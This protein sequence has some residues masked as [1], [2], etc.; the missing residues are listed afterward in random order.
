MEKIRNDRG[1]SATR[2]A[3]AVIPRN[4]QPWKFDAI[5]RNFVPASRPSATLQSELDGLKQFVPEGPVK[6]RVLICRQPG[7]YDTLLRESNDVRPVLHVHEYDL[8]DTV[9]AMRHAVKYSMAYILREELRQYDVCHLSVYPPGTTEFVSKNEYGADGWPGPIST[10]LVPTTKDPYVIVALNPQ[11]FTVSVRVL[12]SR[13]PGKYDSLLGEKDVDIRPVLGE[14]GLFETVDAMCHVVRTDILSNAQCENDVDDLKVYPPGT[15]EFVSKNEYGADGGPGPIS[16]PLV[17]T[18]K[19]PY[20]IVVHTKLFPVRVRVLISRQPGKYEI[21]GESDVRPVLNQHQLRGTVDAMR[22]AVMDHIM[23][24][25]LRR[26][27]VDDL[28]VYPPGTTEFVSKNEYV[29]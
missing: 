10:P 29:V 4:L 23:A 24:D 3:T 20:V 21:V 13:Q 28:K 26:Y 27:E 8:G 5:T 19:D 22:H 18:M 17:P 2:E 16:T 6:V 9:A 7:K 14:H 11:L 1:K 12:I 25:E 15:T